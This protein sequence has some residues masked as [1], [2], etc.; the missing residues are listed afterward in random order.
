MNAGLLHAERA[1]RNQDNGQPPNGCH[2]DDEDDD[3]LL[4]SQKMEFWK[5]DD[6]GDP[7]PWLNRCERYFRVRCTPENRHVAYACFYLTDDA[8]LW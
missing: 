8:Q 5:Y 3:G 1:L 2:H 7:L 6:I 4:I